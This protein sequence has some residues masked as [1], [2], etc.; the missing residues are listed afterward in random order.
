M[1]TD[2]LAR[3]D[4]NRRIKAAACLRAPD[5]HVA[6]VLRDGRVERVVVLAHNSAQLKA[7][8][9]MLNPDRLRT[10]HGLVEGSYRV[11]TLDK[12]AEAPRPWSAEDELRV[13]RAEIAQFAAE[14]ATRRSIDEQILADKMAEY[15][16]FAAAL[17]GLELGD[18]ELAD[19]AS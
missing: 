11:T 9:E 4:K 13:R 16:E 1:I 7:D 10:D 19:A 8:P 6:E 5:M 3:I 18:L 17:A 12:S 15:E 2:L 14:A